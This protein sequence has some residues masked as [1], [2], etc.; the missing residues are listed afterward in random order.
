[1]TETQLAILR[2]IQAS[3]AAPNAASIQTGTAS[4]MATGTVHKLL[5]RFVERGLVRRLPAERGLVH[6]GPPRPRYILTA[7]GAKVLEGLAH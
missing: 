7:K 5:A 6:R 2:A 3:P 4:K 1:M